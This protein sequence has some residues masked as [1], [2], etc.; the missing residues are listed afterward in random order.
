MIAGSDRPSGESG[1]IPN[2]QSNG[3]GMMLTILNNNNNTVIHGRGQSVFQSP[4][5]FFSPSPDLHDRM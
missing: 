2:V 5:P 1:D 3:R 4:G